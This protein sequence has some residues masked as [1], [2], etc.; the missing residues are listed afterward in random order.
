[1][2][3]HQK[4]TCQGQSTQLRAAL[5]STH[6]TATR[7]QRELVEGL[8]PGEDPEVHGRRIRQALDGQAEH[9]ADAA[10]EATDRAPPNA[11]HCMERED[12]RAALKDEERVIQQARDIVERDGGGK[13]TMDT[14]WGMG[15]DW[16][17]GEPLK[18]AERALKRPS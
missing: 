17:P 15:T 16:D 3:D 6:E 18:R 9:L 14:L 5:A 12:L 4:P 7:V 2:A 13:E 10:I 8:P 1:M 11:A